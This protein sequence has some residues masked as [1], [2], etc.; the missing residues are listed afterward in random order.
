VTLLSRHRHV[1]VRRLF[2]ASLVV[3]V[4]SAG[5]AGQTTKI[6]TSSIGP[7]VGQ[8]VPEFSGTDQFGRMHTL[9]SSL[10]AKGAMLVFFRSADW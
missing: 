2:L 10:G 5:V 9:A 4:C 8:R 1:V 3:V 7:K 6:D